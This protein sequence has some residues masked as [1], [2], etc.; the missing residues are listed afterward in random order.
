MNGNM[1]GKMAGKLILITLA[2]NKKFVSDMLNLNQL[3]KLDARNLG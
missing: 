2:L 3:K 1:V